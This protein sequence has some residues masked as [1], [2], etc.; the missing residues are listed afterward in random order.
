VSEKDD[1]Q[2]KGL[3]FG[4]WKLV[5]LGGTSTGN[6]ELCHRHATKATAK[7]IANGTAGKVRWNRLGRYYQANTFGL[8]LLYAADCEAKEG[9][10]ETEMQIREWLAEYERIAQSLIEAVS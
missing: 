10:T 9:C 4:D 3:V 6:W 8:A 2:T 1:I 5:P 7:T